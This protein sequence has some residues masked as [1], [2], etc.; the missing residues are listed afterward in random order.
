MIPTLQKKTK[1]INETNPSE[2]LKIRY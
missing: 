1:I 2:T